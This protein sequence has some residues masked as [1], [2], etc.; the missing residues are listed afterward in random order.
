VSEVP[1]ENA[2]EWLA[3]IRRHPKVAPMDIENAEFVL[4]L[5]R[6]SDYEDVTDSEVNR[7]THRL[8]FVLGCLR[9]VEAAEHGRVDFLLLI[10]DGHN[11]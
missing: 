10:P 5:V 4:D 7:R 11:R 1:I 8:R 3:A 9:A 6:R 2:D